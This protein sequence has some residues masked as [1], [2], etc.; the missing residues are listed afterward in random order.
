MTSTF[1]W[2]MPNKSILVLHLYNNKCF[3]RAISDPLAC[4]WACDSS[5][6][7]SWLPYEHSMGSVRFARAVRPQRAKMCSAYYISDLKTTVLTFEPSIQGISS[8]TGKSNLALREGR[9]DIF[10]IL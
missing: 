9:K 7:P 6:E 2:A 8:Q 5:L 1:T 10:D 4:N 3:V